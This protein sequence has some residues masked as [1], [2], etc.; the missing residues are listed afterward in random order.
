M[1]SIPDG[2]E[3][4]ERSPRLATLKDVAARAGVSVSTVARVLH[5]NGYVSGVT[6]DTVEAALAESG[7]QINT[8]AQRLRKQRSSE[9]GHIL[10]SISPNPFFAGVALG[11]ERAAAE[12]GCTLLFHNTHGDTGLERAGVEALLQRRVEAILFTTVTDE[13]NVERALAAGVPV[14]QVERVSDVETHA[15][16]VDN[17]RGAFD[18]TEHLLR[19]GHRRVACLGVD[20]EQRATLGTAPHR[21]VVERERLSGYHDALRSFGLPVDDDLVVLG[22]SYYDGPAAR[23]AVRHWLQLPK[24]RRPT[25]IFATCDIMAAGVLQEAHVDRLRVPDDLSV[26]G[27]D[28][29]YAGHLTPPLTTVRQPMDELGRAA[30][31]LAMTSRVAGGAAAPLRERLTTRLIVRESTAPPAG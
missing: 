16:T 9:I 23:G 12:Y 6:R 27:F 19:L 15:V 28:D 29:T 22:P 17:Y 8:V 26:V 11:S 1:A 5:D 7:Y 21:R 18:A 10:D 25:A 24:A 13:G 3:T 30:V 14:V 2:V 20:P 4:S 31:R